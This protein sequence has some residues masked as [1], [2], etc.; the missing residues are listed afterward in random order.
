MLFYKDL[1]IKTLPLHFMGE[2]WLLF[3][4]YV[5]NNQILQS[6][7]SLLGK[8]QSFQ[9]KFIFGNNLNLNL[10]F[11]CLSSSTFKYEF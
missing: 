9:V 6:E 5:I 4:F 2:K 7:S 3:V 10:V 1:E 8:H 11:K